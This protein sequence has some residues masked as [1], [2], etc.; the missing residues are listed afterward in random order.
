MRA[1]AAAAALA[2]ALALALAAASGAQPVPALTGRV[3]DGAEVLSPWVED[4][5]TARLA[6]LEDSTTAQLVVLTVPSLGGEPIEP[7]ANRVF[8]A[9]GL[10]Q[11][12]A[13]NGV[14]LL[15]ARDDRELRIEVG[16]GLEGVLTDAESSSIIRNVIVPRFRDGDYDAG[17]L[18]GVDAVLDRVG[19]GGGRRPAARALGGEIARTY[20]SNRD[21]PSDRRGDPFF[22]LL[23]LLLPT[24]MWVGTMRAGSSDVLGLGCMTLFL[25]VF[26]VIGAMIWT[27]G[28]WRSL[29]LLVLIPVVSTLLNEVLGGHPTIGPARAARRKLDAEISRA[30]ARGDAAVV[31]DGVRHRVPPRPSRSSSGSSFG[32]SSSGSSFS[33]GGG[34]SGGGGA[35]GSW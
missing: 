8:R 17:V 25:S 19:G 15:V 10:G 14:L 12:E 22:G 13:D 34:S 27:G 9:W 23:W 35:S 26:F 20:R 6:A 28:D 1:E 29:G 24:A 7:Y 4:A 3:V 18:N 2:L 11:A 30:Q 21:R 33:G 16:Y 5:L 32:S 31:V